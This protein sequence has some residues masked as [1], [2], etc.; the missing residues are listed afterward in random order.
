MSTKLEKELGWRPQETF[1]TGIR[2]TVEWYLNNQD[3]VDNV[4]SGE[5]KNWVQKQYS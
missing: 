3:W 4:A 1:E 2:K 5:Y